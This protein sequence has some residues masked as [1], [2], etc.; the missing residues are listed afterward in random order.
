MAD[1]QSRAAGARARACAHDNA[2]NFSLDLSPPPFPGG[3]SQ[4]HKKGARIS[5]FLFYC[6]GIF[7]TR[8]KAA[9]AIATMNNEL[10]SRGTARAPTRETERTRRV[11]GV[12]II[13]FF[14]Y[15]YAFCA[16]ELNA[17]ELFLMHALYCT[18]VLI[19]MLNLFFK[20]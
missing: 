15:D 12:I 9:V 5:C 19:T 7:N 3:R 20:S 13:I 4:S 17:R 8:D 1:T 6:P 14:F 11:A 2:N 18:G 16:F 10:Y